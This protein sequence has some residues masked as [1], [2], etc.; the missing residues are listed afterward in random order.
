MTRQI[1]V[2]GDPV[3][4]SLSPQM[5]TAAFEVVGL[6]WTY[7]RLCVP[8]HE[9]RARWD[10]LGSEF[11]GLNVTAPLKEDVARLV[12]RVTT[13]ASRCGSVNTVIFEAGGALGDSTDG[14]GFMTALARAGMQQVQCAAVLGTGGAAKAVVA[15]LAESG[16]RVTVLGRNLAAGR[17]MV[18]E[19]GEAM[20]AEVA[21]APLG[22][23]ELAGAL[24]GADLLVNA[25]PLGGTSFPLSSPVPETVRLAAGLTVV[26]LVY[27]PRRTAL[28]ERAD[29]AGCRVVEGVE[30]LVAQGALSFERW[31]GRQAPVEI[32]RRAAYRALDGLPAGSSL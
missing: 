1:A 29:A 11:W 14:E 9:L 18:H 20:G 31:T 26:D 27:R 10:G 23:Q 19:L 13:T 21:Y 5:H 24:D 16:S 2:I 17:E 6:D 15:A 12:T 25:T 28:L 32:M 22:A 4:H 7:Q 3:D 8:R 30:M